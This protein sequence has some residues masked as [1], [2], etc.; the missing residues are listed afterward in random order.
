[1]RQL[2]ITLLIAIVFTSCTQPKITQ[3]TN[4]ESAKG[5]ADIAESPARA[6]FIKPGAERTKLYFNRLNELKVGVVANQTSLIHHVHLVD[7]LLSSGIQVVKVYTPEHGFRGNAD[8][9]E[10]VNNQVDAKTGLQLVSLYGD[11][12]KPTPDDLSGIDIMVFDLQDVGARFYTYI[13]TLTLVMEACAE[14]GIPLLVLDRPNPNGFFIDGPVLESQYQS[15]VGMHPVPVVHGM[16]MAEYARMVN[17]EKWLNNSVQCDLDW[18]PV[19]GYNHHK[20]YT[21]P[22]KPSPNLPDME[23]VYLYPSLCFFE[24][25]VVSVGRGTDTPFTI[26]GFPGN[27]I[28]NYTFRPES[29]PGASLKPPYMN[30]E[31][32]GYN[33]SNEVAGIKSRPGLRLEWL[34]EFYNHYPEKDKFFNSFFDKLAGTDLLRNQ[35]RNNISAHEIRESWK[36]GLENFQQ[37]RRK[38]LIYRDF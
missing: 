37:I 10:L 28:G 4:T 25:T 34:I 23:S 32:R 22:V 33:L 15:F 14:Q 3:Q 21:L 30:E 12:R 11:H 38:Y 29:R 26:I 9:G 17:G 27:T 20:K 31:C 5:R 19:G 6:E 16:T 13:S 7:S 35:I 36:E 2:F 8:A 1:M 24:G 18:V